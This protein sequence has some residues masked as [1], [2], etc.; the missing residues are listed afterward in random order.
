MGYKLG[1][2]YWESPVYVDPD[3][4][5]LMVTLLVQNIKDLRI[6]LI[7]LREELHNICDDNNKN[8]S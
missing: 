5:Q 3:V 8:L 4:H 6:E 2:T 1:F 7:K